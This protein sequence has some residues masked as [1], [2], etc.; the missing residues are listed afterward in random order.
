LDESRRIW[1]KILF[2]MLV[3][4]K[5]QEILAILGAKSYNN[6]IT[7]LKYEKGKEKWH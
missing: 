4:C 6:L 5:P 3:S 1:K 2:L 7:I